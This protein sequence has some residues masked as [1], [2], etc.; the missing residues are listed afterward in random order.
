M[1]W[2]LENGLYFPTGYC[3]FCDFCF[4]IGLDDWTVEFSIIAS[5]GTNCKTNGLFTFREADYNSN[6]DSNPIPA[7][8][9]LDGNLNMT[10][11]SM[12]S[13]AQYNVSI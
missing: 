6:S 8:G 1:S 9:S 4:T 3:D 12:K 10:T 7:V 13:S 5:N 11:C 2:Q